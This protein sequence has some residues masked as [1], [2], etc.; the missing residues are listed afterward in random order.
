MWTGGNIFMSFS[1]PDGWQTIIHYATRAVSVE[2]L[3]HNW[4]IRK[5][6]GL[7]VYKS[8]GTLWHRRTKNGVHSRNCANATRA[9][10]IF[11]ISS[12]GNTSWFMLYFA[13]SIRS[14]D[15]IINLCSSQWPCNSVVNFTS[16]QWFLLPTSIHCSFSPLKFEALC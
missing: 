4:N 1:R 5:T 8:V 6:L 7:L 10:N 16:R 15:Y 12:T 9:F 13:L 2:V 14:S 3:M 11:L